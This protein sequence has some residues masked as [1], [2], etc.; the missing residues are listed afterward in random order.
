MSRTARI[1]RE[2][3]ETRIEV[4]LNLDG[5]GDWEIETGVAFFDHMLSHVAKHGLFDLRVKA[6]GD[7]QVDDHHT[8]EDVGICLGGA[9]KKA[10]GDRSGIRR[11]GS[12]LCPMM[13]ALARVALDLGGRPYLA[14]RC[15]Y[16]ASRVGKFD[17][18]L[19][20]EFF[21]TFATNAGV[22]LHI[23]VLHGSNAHHMVESVF[24]GFG[25][26]LRE[27]VSLDERRKGV[28]STKGVL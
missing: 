5:A 26:A 27:A 25:R 23:E 19:V 24:K 6:R 18:Q 28:P 21:T 22:D 7:T 12:A 9:L 1:K 20:E 11:F 3:S 16:T 13:D 15:P 14:Y 4:D 2:T 17:L 8:V 10:L